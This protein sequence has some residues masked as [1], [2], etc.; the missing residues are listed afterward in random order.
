MKRSTL[1]LLSAIFLAA[2]A[3]AG[4]QSA[5]PA[6]SLTASC[7][8]CAP[9]EGVVFQGSGYKPKAQVEITIAGPVSY[10]I[11]TTVDSN[12]NIYVDYGTILVYDAGSYLVTASAVSGR[13]ITPL[14]QTSF[15]VQ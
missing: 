8:V 1:I 15:S 10:T 3:V 4:H 12:G 2:F 7:V 9:G 11:I 14:A 5:G 13:S 6:P